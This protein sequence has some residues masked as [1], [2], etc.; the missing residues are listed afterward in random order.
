MALTR[1]AG[2]GLYEIVSALGVGGMGEVYGARD[3]KFE[4]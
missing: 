2:L 4:S 3:R 1:G